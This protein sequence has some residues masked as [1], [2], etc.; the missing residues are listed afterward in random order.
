MSVKPIPEGYHSV[1]P[2]LGI[3]KAAEAIEF[4]K[5]AFGATQVMRLD[6]PDGRVG[7]AELRIGDAAIMLGTPCDEMS[8]S[9]PTERTSVALQ[10]Y[11]TDVDAQ[12][13][14][15]VAAGASAVSEPE[16]RFYGDRS[17]SVKD[18]FGHLWYLATR[19]EDLTEEQI[20]QRAMAMFKQG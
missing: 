15:A 20:R 10:L 5:K 19:K 3:N 4:Y 1:T 13:K 11:V 6:M 2:Y 9:N 14:Q 18:P 8:L 16:D 7:H 12:F 17:G